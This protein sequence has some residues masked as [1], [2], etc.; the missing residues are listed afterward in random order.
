MADSRGLRLCF[1]VRCDFSVS[2]NVDVDVRFAKCKGFE[3][4]EREKR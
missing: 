4:L 3:V 2:T 1:V